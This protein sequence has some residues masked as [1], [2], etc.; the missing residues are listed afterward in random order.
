[1]QFFYSAQ[2]TLHGLR[3]ARQRYRAGE[4]VERVGGNEA[5][6]LPGLGL[7]QDLHSALQVHVLLSPPVGLLRWLVLLRA[8]KIQRPFSAFK[9]PESTNPFKVRVKNNNLDGIPCSC[10][11]WIPYFEPSTCL[12]GG[13]RTRRK[14]QRVSARRPTAP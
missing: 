10:L 11:D 4:K 2:G 1:M 14:H 12:A 6:M 8:S 3:N 13:G 9:F 7:C 5:F